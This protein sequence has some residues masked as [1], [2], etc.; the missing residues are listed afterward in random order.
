LVILGF[1]LEL[2]VIVALETLVW[3]EFSGISAHWDLHWTESPGWRGS[4]LVVVGHYEMLRNH[5]DIG[6]R[7]VVNHGLALQGGLLGFVKMI[8]VFKERVLVE[9]LRRLGRLFLRITHHSKALGLKL[10]EFE[11]LLAFRIRVRV[12]VHR[13]NGTNS[14]WVFKV[15]VPKRRFGR[16]S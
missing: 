12:E 8:L 1:D 16:L 9:K 7:V 6:K 3:R 11:R 15:V 4:F 2:C 14:R 13:W 5:I 10:L